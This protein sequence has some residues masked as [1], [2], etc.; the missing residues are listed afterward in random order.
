MHPEG[1]N[2]AVKSNLTHTYVH[3][4]VCMCIYNHSKNRHPIFWYFLDLQKIPDL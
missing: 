1:K 4:Y 2:V 3:R